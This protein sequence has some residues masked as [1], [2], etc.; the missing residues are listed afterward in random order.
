MAVPG[1]DASSFEFRKS[2]FAR[3]H[4]VTCSEV[5]R[6]LSPCIDASKGPADASGLKLSCSNNNCGGD[7]PDASA[8]IPRLELTEENV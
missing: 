1:T 4:V 6:L 5:K 8:P 3:K 2:H 7:A